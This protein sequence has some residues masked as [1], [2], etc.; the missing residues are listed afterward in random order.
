MRKGEANE[1]AW[2]LAREL[3]TTSQGYIGASNA[4]PAMVPAGECRKDIRAGTSAV[5]GLETRASAHANEM[6]S[7]VLLGSAAG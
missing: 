2:G 5:R 3:T 6:H 1:R 4:A 7:I